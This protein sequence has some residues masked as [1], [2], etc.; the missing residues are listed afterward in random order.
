MTTRQK[1]K[2]EVNFHTLVREAVNKEVELLDKYLVF[3]SQEEKKAAKAGDVEA[4]S[5]AQERIIRLAQGISAIK[6]QT[7][8]AA[9]QAQASA[10]MA[11]LGSL[12][13]R[14]TAKESR[15]ETRA[16]EDLAV[17]RAQMLADKAAGK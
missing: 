16:V 13:K 10:A 9:A 5:R 11:L 1:K 8:V 7:V 12:G 3:A 14:A 15:D 6:A 17:M 4:R 2:Q